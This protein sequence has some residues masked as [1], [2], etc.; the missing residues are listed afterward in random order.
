MATDELEADHRP[1]FAPWKIDDEE[2]SEDLS[3]QPRRDLLSVT[4]GLLSR[5]SSR[6]WGL[7]ICGVLVGGTSRVKGRCR[8]QHPLQHHPRHWR[9][10]HHQHHYPHRHHHQHHPLLFLIQGVAIAPLSCQ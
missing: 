7:V 2:E 3:S 8:R 1:D 6:T 9:H 4:H 5:S 10:H